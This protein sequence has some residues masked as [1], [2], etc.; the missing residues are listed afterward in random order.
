MFVGLN[1]NGVFFSYM[2]SE[3]P[4]DAEF[5]RLFGTQSFLEKELV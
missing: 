2:C 1:D 5:A 4:G 3:V